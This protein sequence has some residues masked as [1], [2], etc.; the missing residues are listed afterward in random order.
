MGGYFALP[1]SPVGEEEKEN[2][3]SPSPAGE[4][5]GEGI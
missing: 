5:W 2:T 4:G 1:S 3:L